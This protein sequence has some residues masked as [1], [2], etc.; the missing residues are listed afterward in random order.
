M[1]IQSVDKL[2]VPPHSIMRAIWLLVIC[3][4]ASSLP[5]LALDQDDEWRSIVS[6]ELESLAK[7]DVILDCNIRETDPPDN[8]GG[9][10]GG[11]QRGINKQ[12][13]SSMLKGD[14]LF[15]VG[16]FELLI[17]PQKDIALV[18]VDDKIPNLKFYS[19]ETRFVCTQTHNDTPIQPNHMVYC[20]GKLFDWKE[21]A[22]QV[23]K[24]SKIRVASSGDQTDIRL[25]LDADQ[26][27]NPGI[28]D[29]VGLLGA[30]RQRISMAVNPFA[31][32]AVD[33]TLNVRLN[34]AKQIS[35]LSFEIQY[36]DPMKEL[37]NQG[38]NGK[39]V[40]PRALRG[41]K[42]TKAEEAT[43]VLG[44]IINLNVEVKEK[45]SDKLLSY[46]EK[47]RDM[48]KENKAQ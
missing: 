9:L 25:V 26:F 21:V 1:A 40:V 43:M 16:D 15:Y 4:L 14:S 10:L 11:I 17:T 12:V 19:T 3:W 46:V 38:N 23:Q 33:V 20:M 35:M 30:K 34:A 27:S 24:D 28:T 6:S 47:A 36:D 48:L 5:V 22:E 44:K 32:S 31:P 2:T 39:P 18:S 29:V 7:R 37:M 41:G 45:G 8:E 13:M 42:R